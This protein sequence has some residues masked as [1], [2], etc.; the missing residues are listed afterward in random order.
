[1]MASLFLLKQK[2][3]N[4]QMSPLMSVRDARIL[5]IASIFGPEHDLEQRLQ[6]MEVR[7]QKRRRDIDRRCKET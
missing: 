1:M 4:E 7:H 3:D 6:Q 5:L 2:I